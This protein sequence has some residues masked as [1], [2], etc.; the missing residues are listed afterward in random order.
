MS[1]IIEFQ[2][3]LEERAVRTQLDSLKEQIALKSMMMQAILILLEN[4][5]LQSQISIK[6]FHKLNT[7]V[8]LLRQ[9]Y[10]K[11]KAGSPRESVESHIPVQLELPYVYTRRS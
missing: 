2:V 11:I 7:E 3:K 9:Q 4:L 1:K 8:L 10:S 5:E 6:D